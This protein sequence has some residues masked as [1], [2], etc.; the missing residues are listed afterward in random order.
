MDPARK[1]SRKYCPSHGVW[2]AK[3]SLRWVQILLGILIL[4]LTGA[5]TFGNE[6]GNVLPFIIASP[7]V[8]PVPDHFLGMKGSVA[9]RPRRFQVVLALLSPLGP[10]RGHHL[11]QA[12]RPPGHF[13]A[14]SRCHGYDHMAGSRWI[15]RRLGIH[16]HGHRPERH[17]EVPYQPRL[18]VQW[19]R[20]LTSRGQCK[21]SRTW[22]LSW[23]CLCA[24]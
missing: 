22:P 2:V 6:V 21:M 24:Y 16:W 20:P 19:C 8:S 3:A 14:S 17:P 23:S 1:E 13:P 7:S 11:A 5:L 12:S 15:Q 4:A 9:N 18:Q 10:L